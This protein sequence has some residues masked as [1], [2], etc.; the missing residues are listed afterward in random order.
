[1]GLLAVSTDEIMDEEGY[2]QGEDAGAPLLRSR[3]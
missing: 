2:D 3:H 1:M